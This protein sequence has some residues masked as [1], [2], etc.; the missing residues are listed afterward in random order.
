MSIGQLVFFVTLKSSLKSQLKAERPEKNPALKMSE[1]LKIVLATRRTS[2]K[3]SRISECILV[4][5]PITYKP[6]WVFPIFTPHFLL[7]I[8]IAHILTP[9]ELGG[10][11]GEVPHPL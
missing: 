8:F 4:A 3:E 6:I 1:R 7:P 5:I 11:A 2:N 10:P 9:P